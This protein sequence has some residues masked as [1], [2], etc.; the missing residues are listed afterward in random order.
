M[1]N[2]LNRIQLTLR[3]R[4]I[5]AT[6]CNV[7]RA[8]GLNIPF[9]GAAVGCIHGA[10]SIHA[11]HIGNVTM[12]KVISVCIGCGRSDTQRRSTDTGDPYTFGSILFHLI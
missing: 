6:D 3:A 5:D 2:D 10:L 1:D 9:V 12:S 4:I 11:G 7:V 8:A